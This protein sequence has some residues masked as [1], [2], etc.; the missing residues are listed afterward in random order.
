MKNKAALIF[1]LIIS[2]IVFMFYNAESVN[3]EN[4]AVLTGIGMDIEKKGDQTLYIVSHNNINFVNKKRVFVTVAGKGKTIGETRKTRQRTMEKKASLGLEKVYIIGEEN[5]RN[6]LSNYIN[7]LFGNPALNDTGICMVCKG[8][9]L[10][11]LKHKQ[12]G[13]PDITD[14]L[15]QLII[16][17]RNYNFFSENYKLFDLYMILDSEGRNLSLPY[18]E[19]INGSVQ[20]T[21]IAIF[22]GEKMIDV[23]PISEARILNM[24]KESNSR[25]EITIMKDEQKFASIYTVIKRR[26]SCNFE[27]NKYNFTINLDAKCSVINNKLYKDLDNSP[28]DINKLQKSIE[29]KIVEDSNNFIS[30]MKSNYKVDCLDLGRCAAAKYGRRKGIDWNSIVCDSNINVKVKAKI[31]KLGRGNY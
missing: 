27:N 5:A 1:F 7:I 31:E 9:A 30:N 25:G 2:L 21:G 16:E 3:V 6:G 19:N 11:L 17:N 13:V 24:L 10:D 28:Q 4:M 23:V 29:R 22:N 8:K 18:V 14:F 26:V 12:E 20:I 15:D